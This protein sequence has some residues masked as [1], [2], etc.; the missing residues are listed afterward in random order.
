MPTC[1]REALVIAGFAFRRASDYKLD[2]CNFI[3]VGIGSDGSF[4]P[5]R[6]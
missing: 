5:K 1:T 6:D 4:F 3:I 2:S